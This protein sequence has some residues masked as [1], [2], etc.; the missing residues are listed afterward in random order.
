M[1][2]AVAAGSGLN[3][4]ALSD[5]S[6][7]NVSRVSKCSPGRAS[8]SEEEAVSQV[9]RPHLLPDRPDL[10]P[11]VRSRLEDDFRRFAEHGLPADLASYLSDSY[12]LQI[13]G[14][15]AG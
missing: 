4:V 2:H 1:A 13:A 14:P 12:G 15:Y 8:P 10:L 11:A 9:A 5:R 7:P 3:E 6:R